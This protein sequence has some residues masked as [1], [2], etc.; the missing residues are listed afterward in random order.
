M[1]Y[2][3]EA[4]VLAAETSSCA[5]TCPQALTDAPGRGSGRPFGVVTRRGL[6]VAFETGIGPGLRRVERPLS[7]S[8]AYRDLMRRDL[9]CIAVRRHIIAG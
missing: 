5:Q 8:A 2:R 9:H 1:N 3:P 6:G 7:V 4:L